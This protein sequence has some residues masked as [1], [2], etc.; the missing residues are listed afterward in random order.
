MPK[1]PAKGC[2]IDHIIVLGFICIVC[3]VHVSAMMEKRCVAGLQ[4]WWAR[5]AAHFLHRACSPPFFPMQQ[6]ASNRTALAAGSPANAH[7]ASSL[8]HSADVLS[9]FMLQKGIQQQPA[10]AQR[11]GSKHLNSHPRSAQQQP[12]RAASKVGQKP[13]AGTARV[14]QSAGAAAPASALSYRDAVREGLRGSES[15]SHCIPGL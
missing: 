11:R 3:G 13:R 7:E 10:Q 12:P 9:H 2:H 5:C 6:Q 14:Q 4:L 1:R 8:A 15:A